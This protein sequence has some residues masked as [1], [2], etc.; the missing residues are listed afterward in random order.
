VEFFPQSKREVITGKISLNSSTYPCLIDLIRYIKINQ[1][2]TEGGIKYGHRNF[3]V[4]KGTC[5][6][7]LGPVPDEWD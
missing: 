6:N 5:E 1:T 7:Q 3:E 4:R 2:I